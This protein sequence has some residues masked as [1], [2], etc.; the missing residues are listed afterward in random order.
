LF[1]PAAT[2]P[3]VIAR[4]RMAV[5][6]LVQRPEFAEKLAAAGSGEPFA[7]SPDEMVALIHAD[8]ERFG[9]VV[10]ANGLKLE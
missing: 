5:S 8:S 1:V 2:P 6:A 4:L 9:R 7:T 3:A 10:K